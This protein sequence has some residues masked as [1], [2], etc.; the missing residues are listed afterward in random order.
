V[1]SGARGN[2]TPFFFLGRIS[3]VTSSS[4]GSL[5]YLVVDI[6]HFSTGIA[7]SI[8]TRHRLIF[9]EKGEALFPMVFQVFLSPRGFG[10][11]QSSFPNA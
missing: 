6:A 3:E 5:F 9:S 8:L 11:A 10:L 1:D 7:L 4:T 2:G